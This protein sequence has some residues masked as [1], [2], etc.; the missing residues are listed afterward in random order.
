MPSYNF[1]N[2]IIYKLCCLDLNVPY[3]YVGY[4]TNF[5]K[6]KAKHKYNCH[7]KEL[8]KYNL[9][10]YQTIRENGG[11][12]NWCMVKVEDYACNDKL[13]ATKRERYWYETLNADLN[14]II[15]F[16]SKEGKKKKIKN[17]TKQTKKNKLNIRK[18]I[19]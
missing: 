4:T 1:Q 5:V 11:W 2:T 16:R 12:E 7:S 19:I 14:A 10:V 13:D 3:V 17:I 6:R 18:T 8:K 15:P 9:K